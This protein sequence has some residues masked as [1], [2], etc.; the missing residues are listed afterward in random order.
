MSLKTQALKNVASSWA[1]LGTSIAV[2]FFL[3][4]FILHRLGDDAFGLWILVFSVTGYYGLFDFGI[5]SSLV[6]YV[7]KFK[8]TG[9]TDQLACLINT[10]LFSYSCVGIFLMALTVTGSP[11][12]ERFFHIPPALRGDA[13]ILFLIVGTAL[14]VGFPLAV[15]GGILEGLQSFYVINWTQIIA[16][17][18]RAVLILLALW[19][20]LGVKTVTLITVALPLIGSAVNFVIA[21]RLLDVPY[22][23]RY[24]NRETFRQVR[25]YGSVTFM[26][27]VAGRLRF[28]TDAVIIGSFLS[29]SAI[30]YFAVGAR[31]VDY[32]G[33]VVSSLAQIFTPMS[34]QFH[35]TGDYDRLRR[36]F[37]AGNRVCALTMFPVCTA[38]IIVGK[39][40]IEAWVG[41]RY[42]SSY[43][44][45]LI[46]LIPSSL[47]YA[48]A[49]SNRILFGMSRHRTLAVVV[50]LEGIANVILSIVLIRPFGIV[51]DAIGTAIPLSCTAL[52]FL[53]RHL[54]RQLGVPLWRFVRESFLY[55][56]LFCLPMAV[57]LMVMQHFF[58]AHG[59]RQLVLNLVV[60]LAA[61]SVGL[62]WV[63]LTREPAGIQLRGRMVQYFQQASGR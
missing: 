35:A 25:D 42:V 9:E 48:Q 15:S 5:R 26:I 12:V 27:I 11:Y 31:L 21:R 33:E 52:F 8:A 32:A 29:A 19:H 2:G 45:L 36:I 7:A 37:L 34:S 28:K 18:L 20:G 41:A 10:S 39:S 59:Y 53:P 47:Y 22:G 24:V 16:T 61:Y 40:V 58:Y 63:F 30:T 54:C 6:R 50:L 56:V 43:I 38:L 3:S 1:G 57:V 49:T 51:G 4:P 14:A 17:L 60:G 44:I 23:M 55:P 13:R 62:F 46:L